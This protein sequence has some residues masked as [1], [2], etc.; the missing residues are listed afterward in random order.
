M[1]KF[2][3]CCLAGF[4]LVLSACSDD[5]EPT[6][7]KSLVVA[8]PLSIT[9]SAN[10][11]AA[12][13]AY[14]RNG[15][16]RQWHVTSAS[17]ETLCTYDYPTSNSISVTTVDKDKPYFNFS[18]SER[19]YVDN[20]TLDADGRALSCDGVMRIY[21]GGDEAEGE[22]IYTY[23]FIYDIAGRLINIER[24]QWRR[25]DN[26][27]VRWT[28]V[29]EWSDGNP[30]RYVEYAAHTTPYTTT[31][32]TYFAEGGSDTYK[33]LMIPSLGQ[34]SP[35]QR[36]GVFGKLPKNLLMTAESENHADHTTQT[37]RYSYSFALTE[38]GSR[39]SSYTVTSDK[40]VPNA[41]YVMT[42]DI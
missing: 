13:F 31:T 2:L 20:I 40:S 32:Y 28:D 23:N 26:A 6:P 3:S 9:S 19:R 17:G 16:V 41:T 27:P 15:R 1:K 10:D 42:W 36:C 38:Q 22:F 8:L 24:A 30:I 39:I 7:V 14:D 25:N 4:A 11:Y 35:L 37:E 21:N 18:G 5:S 29:I 34:F 12:T 33:P